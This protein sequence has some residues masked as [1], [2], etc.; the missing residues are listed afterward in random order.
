M[1]EASRAGSRNFRAEPYEALYEANKGYL[2]HYHANR[3]V[4]RAFIEA[5]TVD[6]RHRDMWWWMRQ[7]HIDRF[8]ALLKRDFGLTE[9]SGIDVRLITEALA[10]L[11]EQ[12][13]YVWY[14][15]ERLNPSVVSVDTAAEIVTRAWYAAFFSPSASHV[16]E[17]TP[18]T[19]AG[20]LSQPSSASA[21]SY[22]EALEE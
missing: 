22:G 14:A 6:S 17:S 12:S 19:A 5:T 7:R 1:F 3:D 15:Q 18:R 4:M 20:T 2:A 16:T 13:A 11:T 10:S 8:V 21:R 9:V